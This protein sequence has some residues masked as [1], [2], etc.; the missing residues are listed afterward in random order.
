[1]ISQNMVFIPIFVFGGFIMKKI[2]LMLL[3]FLLVIQVSF[4]SLTPSAEG[5]EKSTNDEI[6]TEV[7]EET[8]TIDNTENEI[9]M[10]TN[11]EETNI[12]D[13][14]TVPQLQEE[15]KTEAIVSEPQL[16]KD[17]LHNKEEDKKETNK[18]PLLIQEKQIVQEQALDKHLPQTKM[19]KEAFYYYIALLMITI[20]YFIVVKYRRKKHE[21]AD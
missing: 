6:V 4:G 17:S 11:F 12:D 8:P 16:E 18:T 9:L 13:V 7:V 2:L 21:S 1:M 5:N 10:E 19:K 3:S 15:I 20:G 14:S